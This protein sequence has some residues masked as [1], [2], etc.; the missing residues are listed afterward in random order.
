MW[1]LRRWWHEKKPRLVEQLR[2]GTY[3]FRELRAVRSDG[4]VLE[5]WSA[6]DSLVMKAMSI[7]LG[8]VL[9]PILSPRCF[10]LA[11]TGGLKGAVREVHSHLP[12][13]QFV[14]RTDVKGYY[15][16][17][18]HDL[19]YSQVKEYVDDPL[20]L[21]LVRQY[22]ER[23]VS[24]G[25]DYTDIVLGIALGSPLSPLM[26]ALFL[27]PLDDRMAE[28]GCFYVRFMDDWVVLAPT[29]WKL[30]KAIRATNE[31]MEQLQVLKHPDKTFIGRIARGFDFLGY[32]FSPEGLQVAMKTIGRMLDKISRLQ[33]QGASV[34]RI[35][36]YV[37]RWVSWARGLGEHFDIPSIAKNHILLTY[38][39]LLITYY[40]ISFPASGARCVVRAHWG[41]CSALGQLGS[42]V[43]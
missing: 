3:R 28:L 2:A 6:Q 38:Y 11:G 7:V 8:E 26:G 43:L 9:H 35:G 20:V 24:D 25:G 32:W 27:K 30:R 31:L 34:E 1:Q 19:L 4:E 21:V 36:D 17:I 40:L 14:F 33:E 42:W 18:N 10:H 37:R 22:L 23:F 5:I 39:L 15:A 13:H 41:L 16:S 12:E 29:R